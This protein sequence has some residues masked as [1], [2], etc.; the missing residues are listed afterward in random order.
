M[1]A[2]LGFGLLTILLA[3]T[4]MYLMSWAYE[5]HQAA[6]GAGSIRPADLQLGRNVMPRNRRSDCESVY[7]LLWVQTRGAA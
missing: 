2:P 3:C 1:L 7:D 5:T 4:A 6:I